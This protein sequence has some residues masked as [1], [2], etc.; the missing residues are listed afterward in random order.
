VDTIVTTDAGGSRVYDNNAASG[1]TLCAAYAAKKD[2]SV[3]K[4][5]DPPKHY[6]HGIFVDLTNAIV[7][8]C[9]RPIARNLRC[10]T[11]VGFG[12]GYKDLVSRVA[13]VYA[14]GTRNLVCRATVAYAA[15]TKDLVSRC[16]VIFGQAVKDLVSRVTVVY[17]EGT[18]DL[19]SRAEVLKESAANLVCQMT[20]PLVRTSQDFKC[21][22]Y[23]NQVP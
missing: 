2:D 13:V 1:N 10:T 21:Q 15:G 23:A 8:V 12:D 20:Q 6:R 17:G 11:T 16:T 3:V 9:Y 7:E 14:L 19:V 22:V 5:Y 18:A 4:S